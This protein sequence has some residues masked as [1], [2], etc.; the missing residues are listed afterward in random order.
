MR[1]FVEEELSQR[2]DVSWVY[3][4]HLFGN[5]RTPTHCKNR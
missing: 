4:S 3:V 1:D 2:G 5:K